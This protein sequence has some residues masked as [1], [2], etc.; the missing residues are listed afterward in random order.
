MNVEQVRR[1]LVGKGILVKKIIPVGDNGFV[2]LV[3][4]GQKMHIINVFRYVHLEDADEYTV[5][6]DFG[7]I[8]FIEV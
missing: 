3:H 1:Y 6:T 4:K 7:I 2:A 5:D 8:S